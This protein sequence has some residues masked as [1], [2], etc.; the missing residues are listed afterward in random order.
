MAVDRLRV[1]SAGTTEA[2]QT[3]WKHVRQAL[4]SPHVL[5]CGVGFFFGNTAAQSFSVFAPSIIAAMGYSRSKAQLLS[6]GPYVSNANL[7][8][9][10]E[11]NFATGCCLCFFHLG[12]LAL[13][14]L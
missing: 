9:N 10:H 11:A 12:W 3:K 4:L 7:A 1:D 6:V 2:G 14:S 8:P 13:G 5:A